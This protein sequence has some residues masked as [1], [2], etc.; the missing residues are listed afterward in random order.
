[1]N[2]GKVF[3][4]HPERRE[5]SRFLSAMLPKL[6]VIIS[7]ALKKFASKIEIRNETPLLS[8]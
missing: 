5:G 6:N 1:V 4:C 3:F 7:T 2:S 8:E